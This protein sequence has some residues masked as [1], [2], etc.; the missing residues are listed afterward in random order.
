M[1]NVLSLSDQEFL[2]KVMRRFNIKAIAVQW[3]DYSRTRHPDIWC[4]PYDNPPKIVV[5]AEWKRQTQ[6]ERQKRLLHECLHIVGMEHDE[7]IGYS[8]YPDRDI[9]SRRLYATLVK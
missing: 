7:K 6:G 3:S 5:T 1:S 8:T 4:F 9:Y 2:K